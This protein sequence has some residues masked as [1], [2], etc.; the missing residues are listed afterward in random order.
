MS[1]WTDAAKWAKAGDILLYKNP[2]TWSV[3][4]AITVAE[5][6]DTSAD[7]WD[8]YYHAALVVNPVTGV[9]WEQNPPATHWLTLSQEPW[10]RIDGW[11]LNSPL[12][13]DPTRLQMYCQ[14]HLN[15]PYP[16]GM[17]AKFMG[18]DI[19][20]SIGLPGAA[21]W[22]DRLGPTTDARAA[23]CSA[24][25]CLALCAAVGIPG[26][27]ALWPKAPDE[28]RPCD[29]PTGLVHQVASSGLAI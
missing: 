15:I 22:L 25:V 20:G 23:V 8:L 24:E 4:K 2:P 17:I 1:T 16:Y 13:V 6:D 11:R 26:G 27:S 14:G 7:K 18:A 19:I 3:G 12:L 21:K 9:G 10:D 5:H 28:M 29:I